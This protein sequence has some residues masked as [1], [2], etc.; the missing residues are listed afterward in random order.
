M[1]VAVEHRQAVEHWQAVEQPAGKIQVV[2]KHMAPVPNSWLTKR[3]SLNFV[4]L[5][6]LNLLIFKIGVAIIPRI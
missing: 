2:R 4:A 5:L 3:V 1:A 6:K